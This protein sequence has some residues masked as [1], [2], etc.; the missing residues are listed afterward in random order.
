MRSLETYYTNLKPST[1][2]NL[3]FGVVI[4]LA[5][6]ILL[7]YAI[8]FNTNRNRIAD[9]QNS[10]IASCQTTYNAFRQ[11]FAPFLSNHPLTQGEKNDLVR[12][13]EN[14]DLLIAGCKN[15]VNIIDVG[16]DS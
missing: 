7:L 12:F 14:I 4:V 5:T 3:A 1:R 16:G 9:I 2:I 13:Y 8:G 15:Q 6:L 10:R 11:V